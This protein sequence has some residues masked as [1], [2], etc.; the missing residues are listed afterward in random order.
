MKLFAKLIFSLLLLAQLAFAQTV[1]KV[2][3]TADQPIK[4]ARIL[5]RNQSGSIV[6]AM[7]TNERGEFTLPQLLSGDHF[8]TAEV[9]GM[10][11]VGGA[12]KRGSNPGSRRLAF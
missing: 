6:R 11:I 5:I 4:T 2:T 3:D 1:G 8:I 12:Q 9:E 7:F 10:T